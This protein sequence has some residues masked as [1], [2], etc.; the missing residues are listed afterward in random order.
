[1][2]HSTSCRGQ[3]PSTRPVQEAAQL[4][5]SLSRYFEDYN[6]KLFDTDQCIQVKCTQALYLGGVQIE[7]VCNSELR[8]IAEE[9]NRLSKLF[10]CD[11][12]GKY[13]FFWLQAAYGSFFI[14]RSVSRVKL[15]TFVR[16]LPSGFSK[17]V[18]VT[19]GL[20][21]AKQSFL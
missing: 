15:A 10:D 18:F 8:G 7:H 19:L 4:W 2:E 1:M 6:G 11:S 12:D 16:T 14:V 9:I 13:R 3:D 5:T 17:C 20:F 21:G